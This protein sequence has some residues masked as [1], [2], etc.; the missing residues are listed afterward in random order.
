VDFWDEAFEALF[1]CGINY[2]LQPI[3]RRMAPFGSI[4]QGQVKRRNTEF[5]AFFN[6]PFGSVQRF[7]GAENHVQGSGNRSKLGDY[8]QNSAP[9]RFGSDVLQLHA[10]NVSLAISHMDHVSGDFPEYPR[11]VVGLVG[12][13]GGLPVGG[14]TSPKQLHQTPIWSFL[15]RF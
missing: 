6:G 5:Y 8:L 10:C 9:G 4:G 7:G 1:G 11:G 2:F 12:R 15:R 14:P 3:D 13:Q